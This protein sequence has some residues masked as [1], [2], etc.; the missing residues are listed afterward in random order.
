MSKNA[1]EREIRAVPRGGRHSWI[2]AGSD[3]GGKRPAAIY[4]LMSTANPKR[5]I[6]RPGS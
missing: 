3:E 4:T 6:P 5:S 1:A 2:I